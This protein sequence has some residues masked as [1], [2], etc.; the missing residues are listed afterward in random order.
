MP[1]VYV[2][3]ERADD[4]AFFRGG[5]SA[6]RPLVNV[7]FFRC[8]FGAVCLAVYCARARLF[9][10]AD[11][12]RRNL[13]LLQLLIGIVIL[14]PCARLNSLPKVPAQWGCLIVLGAVHSAARVDRPSQTD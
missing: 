8:L 4:A 2:D 6:R 5:A 12:S 9:G 3:C 11:F 1:G 14:A 13:L 10:Q 7:V